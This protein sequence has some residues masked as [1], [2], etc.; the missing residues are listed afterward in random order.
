M[1]HDMVVAEKYETAAIRES[2]KVFCC[3]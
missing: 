3:L 2:T 1:T